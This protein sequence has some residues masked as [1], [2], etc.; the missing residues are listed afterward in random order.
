[1][2]VMRYLWA[3]ALLWGGAAWGQTPAILPTPQMATSSG[4]NLYFSVPSTETFTFPSGGGT[5][6]LTGG[7][8][9]TPSSVTLTN[10]NGLPLSTGVTGNLPNANLASQTANTVLGALVNGTPIDLSIP[11]CAGA[12]NALIFTLGTGFG[13]NTISGGGG[14]GTVN[15]GSAGQLAYYSATGNAVSP[16]AS[17]ISIYNSSGNMGFTLGTGS[18]YGAIDFLTYGGGGTGIIL[19]GSQTGG[20]GGILALPTLAGNDTIADLAGTQTLTNKTI[21]GASNTISNVPSSA[22]IGL[23]TASTYNIGTSGATV[24][25]LTMASPTWVQ[26]NY[27][28]ITTFSGATGSSAAYGAVNITYQDGDSSASTVT[29]NTYGQINFNGPD[30]AGNNPT[31][32]QQSVVATIVN[33]AN[34]KATINTSTLVAGALS[35]RESM[36]P[37]YTI[38]YG[39]SGD[40]LAVSNGTGYSFVSSALSRYVTTSTDTIVQSDQG[41][42]VSYN[43]GST[44]VAV[45]LPATVGPE[46]TDVINLG[47]GT[48]TLT[49]ASGASLNGVS[50]GTIN[51]TPQVVYHLCVAYNAG[52]AA[53]W[54]IK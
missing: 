33:A 31:W 25:T 3:L 24:P 5:V 28:G 39:S 37:Y 44:A 20:T 8:L 51:L 34:A 53:Q 10:A 35:L 15:S 9:G 14:S 12:S 11:S 21:S 52:G 13:C 49:A 38:F 2:E 17:G 46:S 42:E 7:A 41:G 30:S 54:F 16:T 22:I 50:G 26:S 29:G 27:G 23:G 19:Q 32:F 43:D 47:T 4:G 1:M 36:A 40:P 48:V 18:N 45:T 6:A